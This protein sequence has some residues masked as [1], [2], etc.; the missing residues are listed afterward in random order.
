MLALVK[1]TTADFN[2][3]RA[4]I[5]LHPEITPLAPAWTC[6]QQ[7]GSVS[8]KEQGTVPSNIPN[9]RGIF[10]KT[11]TPCMASKKRWWYTKIGWMVYG[12]LGLHNT[13][14]ELH[15]PQKKKKKK[16]N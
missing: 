11:V 12:S 14:E 9:S 3:A 2:L 4:V 16:T 7:V 6:H 8:D 5:S 10:L 15:P 13:P 1:F